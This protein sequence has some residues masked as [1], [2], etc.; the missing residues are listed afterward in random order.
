MIDDPI[1][2]NKVLPTLYAPKFSIFKNFNHTSIFHL[3]PST[4]KLPTVLHRPPSLL[5]P[6]ISMNEREPQ[7]QALSLSRKALSAACFWSMD[8]R[9]KSS[10][11]CLSFFLPARCTASSRAHVFNYS[12]ASERA[13]S[14][15]SRDFSPSLVLTRS[16]AVPVLTYILSGARLYG[17]EKR[18]GYLGLVRLCAEGFLAW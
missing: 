6:L 9:D 2:R 3:I 18:F 10:R 15:D 8:S 5:P 16:V 4:T 13:G 11:R 1:L 12:S 17:E 7:S 14:V